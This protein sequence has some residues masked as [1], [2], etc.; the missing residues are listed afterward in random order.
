MTVRNLCIRRNVIVAIVVDVLAG[1]IVVL[2][3]AFCVCG[4]LGSEEL[5]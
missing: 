1:D 4:F 5:S 3:L 2:F